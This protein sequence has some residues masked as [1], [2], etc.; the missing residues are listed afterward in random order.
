MAGVTPP[1]DE[2]AWRSPAVLWAVSLRALAL[3][4][5]FTYERFQGAGFAVAMLPVLRRL[6]TDRAALSEAVRRHMDY[7]NTNPVMC[8]YV[9]GAAARLEAEV[10]A[11]SPVEMARGFKASVGG[12]VAAL[13]DRLLWGTV[14]PL[15]TVAGILVAL[16]WPVVGV[17]VMLL[18]YNIPHLALRV[19]GIRQGV[20]HGPTAL[21]DITGA[22]FARIT[23]RLADLTALAT[24]LLAGTLVAGPRAVSALGGAGW[25]IWLI[26]AGVSALL[27]ARRRLS[28]TQLGLAGCA[29]GALVALFGGHHGV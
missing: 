17:A 6:W 3:Q 9:L 2:T 27:F 14:R 16:R 13:G 22:P 28:P 12:P 19:R 25:V 1:R 21:R 18:G 10:A 7:F 11:G 8:T 15:A 4:A 5:S 20:E 23:E 29:V 24:G 26:F